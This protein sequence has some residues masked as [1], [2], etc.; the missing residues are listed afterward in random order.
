MTLSFCSLPNI[1]WLQTV[2]LTYPIKVHVGHWSR[3]LY[4]LL[5]LDAFLV[6]DFDSLSLWAELLG[7]VHMLYLQFPH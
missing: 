2:R 4:A 3:A 6:Q 7:E 5:M 1:L